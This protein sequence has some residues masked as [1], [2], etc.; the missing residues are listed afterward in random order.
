MIGVH[1]RCDHFFHVVRQPVI[2]GHQIVKSFRRISRVARLGGE[3]CRRRQSAKRCRISC[4]ASRIVVRRIMRHSA[5]GGV[6]AR[7]AQRFRIHHLSHCAFHQI[8]SA[9]PHEAGLIHHDDDVAQRGQIGSTRNT[10]PHH[11]R[12]LRNVQPLRIREL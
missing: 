4:E 1:Q 10:R 8:R 6:H 12:D 11:R 7:A 5:G 9:Q 3:L 2:G